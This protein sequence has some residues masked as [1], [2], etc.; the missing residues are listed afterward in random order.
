MLDQILNEN[1]CEAQ[2]C[3]EHQHKRTQMMNQIGYAQLTIDTGTSHPTSVTIRG[4]RYVKEY[5]SPPSWSNR[6]RPGSYQLVVIYMGRPPAQSKTKVSRKIQVEARTSRR[7]VFELPAP[8]KIATKPT[9]TP[10]LLATKKPSKLSLEPKPP[11][12]AVSSANPGAWVAVGVGTAVLLGG[13][14]TLGVGYTNGRQLD[15]L[16]NEIRTEI[17]ESNN[18]EQTIQAKLTSGQTALGIREAHGSVQTAIITGWS[19]L[20][21][22]TATTIGGVIWLLFPRKV[23]PDIKVIDGNKTKQNMLY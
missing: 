4:H 2:K 23:Q 7:I 8:H 19:I 13:I 14:I 9:D 3:K 18:P 10:K 11:P 15:S 20:G 16:A 6:V 5:R 12:A 17:N 22:G 21:I 1:L